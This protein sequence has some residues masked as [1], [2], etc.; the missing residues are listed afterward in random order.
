[1]LDYTEIKKSGSVLA[2]LASFGLLKI[3]CICNFK[4][5]LYFSECSKQY[6]LKHS[7]RPLKIYSCYL[8]FLF[9]HWMFYMALEQPVH[10]KYSEM[11]RGHLGKMHTVLINFSIIY[12]QYKPVYIFIL[13]RRGWWKWLWRKRRYQPEARC[14]YLQFTSNFLEL[15]Y[16]ILIELYPSWWVFF[17]QWPV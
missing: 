6:D 4:N 3:W 17:F 12:K 10:I 8:C 13:C 2:S 7:N 11:L 1:M 5:T 15:F 16:D 14:C 9:Q